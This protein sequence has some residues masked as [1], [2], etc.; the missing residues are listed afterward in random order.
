MWKFL[1][2]PNVLPLIGVTISENRFAMVS[3]WMANGNINEFVKAYPEVD[4]LQLLSGVAR[5]LMYIHGNGMVHGDL[6]GANILIDEKHNVR[7]ADFGLLTIMSHTTNLLSSSS[8]SQGGTIR[9][10]SPEL[11]APQQFGFQRSRPTKSSDCYA[12][13]MVMYETI[14]GNLPFHKDPDFVV[15]FKVVKGERPRRRTEFAGTLW[16]VL[17]MCWAPHPND[18][19]SIEGVLQCLETVSSSLDQPSPGMNE[20][21]GDDDDQDSENEYLETPTW[22][23]STISERS[24]PTELNLGHT[25]SPYPELEP[26][27][28]PALLF[29]PL[30]EMSCKKE[31]SGRIQKPSNKEHSAAVDA[32]RSPVGN[33]LD[34]IN[35]GSTFSTGVGPQS[36]PTDA[37]RLLE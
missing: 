23:N 1:K 5:G 15:S 22:M 7:L 25:V 4:R 6:K 24:T 3:D 27:L 20:E 10:M 14:S 13:G 17:E 30:L 16:R 35:V 34:L 36:G 19:P 26:L 29:S 21:T 31:D 8:K 28:E 33:S 9:W 12:L 2:H 11:F 37:S 32:P 18:R